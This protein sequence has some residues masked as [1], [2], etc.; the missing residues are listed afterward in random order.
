MI[1]DF[2]NYC[3]QKAIDYPQYR[4]DIH[5]LYSLAMTEIDDGE[6]PENEIEL[7]KGDIESLIKTGELW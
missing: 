3:T 7:A 4:D 6:S 1:K 5:D 2:V